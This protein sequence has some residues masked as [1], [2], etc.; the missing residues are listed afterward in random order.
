MFG[1]VTLGSYDCPVE[2][3]PW[4]LQITKG[5]PQMGNAFSNNLCYCEGINHVAGEV[6]NTPRK[7]TYNHKNILITC[8]S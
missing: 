8:G 5:I 6:S 7:H 2:W 1:R 3:V 4:G